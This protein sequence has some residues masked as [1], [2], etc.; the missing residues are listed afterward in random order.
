MIELS[1]MLN[2]MDK[3]LFDRTIINKISMKIS[4]FF[5]L[6]S[7]FF[8]PSTFVS[9]QLQNPLNNISSFG[10]L[11][12]AILDIVMMIGFPIAVLAIMYSGFLFVTAQGNSEKLESAKNALLWT[13]IGTAVLLGSWV[14]SVGVSSTIESLRV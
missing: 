9:A 2:N 10:E 5:F 8:I 13:I 11:I 7:A 12:S 1:D 14:L 3:K 4:S 6:I